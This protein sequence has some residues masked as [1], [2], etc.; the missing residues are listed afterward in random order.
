MGWD[1]DGIAASVRMGDLLPALGLF[2]D[3]GLRELL[4]PSAPTL[5]VGVR[6]DPLGPPR[7][8]GPDRIRGALRALGRDLDTRDTVVRRACA[9]PRAHDHVLALDRPK[10]DRGHRYAQRVCSSSLIFLI[11]IRIC[12]PFAPFMQYM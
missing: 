5:Q 9:R 3:R 1:S 10:A 4:D 2:L 7:V 8:H 11:A 6:E 12:S